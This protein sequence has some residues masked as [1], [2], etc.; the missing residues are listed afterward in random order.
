LFRKYNANFVKYNIGCFAQ[1]IP[2]FNALRNNW[3]VITRSSICSIY[4]FTLTRTRVHAVTYMRVLYI[5]GSRCLEQIRRQAS[6]EQRSAGQNPVILENDVQC[7]VTIQKYRLPVVVQ[8]CDGQSTFGLVLRRDGR[9]QAPSS[10]SQ[11]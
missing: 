2:L 10:T 4:T 5:A 1:F 7:A 9:L 3:H 8:A 6:D 11:A